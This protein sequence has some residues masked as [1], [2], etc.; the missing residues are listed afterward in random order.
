MKSIVDDFTEYS[1]NN[2]LAASM[3][4]SVDVSPGEAICR[5]DI[6]I[7]VAIFSIV[8]SGNSLIKSLFVRRSLGR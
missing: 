3:A 5:S 2:L 6:P 1:L 7:F 4:K 8:H